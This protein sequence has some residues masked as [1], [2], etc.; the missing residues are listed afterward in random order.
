M[1]RIISGL[2]CFIILF[3]M[4]GCEQNSNMENLNIY[5]T[6]YP[7]EYVINRLYKNHSTVK[8]IYPNGAN[9]Y[10]YKIT[11]VL[12]TEYSNTDMFIF[13]GLSNEKN[14]IKPMLKENK[15]LKIIDISSDIKYKNGIE[16]LWLDPS[17]LLTIANNIKKGF[18]EYI[19]AKYLEDEI[20]KNY[21]DLKIDL[22]NIEAKYRQVFKNASNNNLIVSNDI[23]LFLNKYGANVISLDSNNE[24]YE[25]NLVIARTLINNNS[26][27]YVYVKDNEEN[28]II[29]SLIAETTV[30]TINLNSLS[31]LTDEQRNNNYD[32]ISL[33]NDNLEKIKKQI[34][35]IK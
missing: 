29:N 32:Y 27:S 14:Y 11:D 31:T 12:L 33:M 15:K 8:S 17:N 25:K 7:I 6:A 23:F 1:K 24:E 28:D 26:V 21:N 34:Y 13:N 10:D 19:S 18:H 4:S 30:T 16:E 20:D 3:L 2:M 22:T 5:T 9:I 35:D